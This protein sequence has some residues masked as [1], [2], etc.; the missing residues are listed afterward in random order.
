MYIYIFSQKVNPDT[1]SPVSSPILLPKPTLYFLAL[2]GSWRAYWMHSHLSINY[3]L[4]VY[5]V[6]VPVPGAGETYTV[7]SSTE[8]SLKEQER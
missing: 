2:L 4:N 3:A 5:N 1:S 6:L 8:V 7:S